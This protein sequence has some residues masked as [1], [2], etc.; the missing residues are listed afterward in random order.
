MDRKLLARAGRRRSV[1]LGGGSIISSGVLAWHLYRSTSPASTP[2]P[3]PV[4]SPVHNPVN[5]SSITSNQSITVAGAAPPLFSVSTR[6]PTPVDTSI[7][8]L[9]LAEPEYIS[10]PTSVQESLEQQ[11][12]GGLE[13]PGLPGPSPAATRQELQ[14]FLPRHLRR[15]WRLLHQAERDS[16][17]GR[18]VSDCRKMNSFMPLLLS[19]DPRPTLVI[20]SSTCGQC[21]SWADWWD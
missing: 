2:A 12:G 13:E 18:A 19:R 7:L 3:S 21:G 14:T 4:H 1:V 15:P 5:R 10:L 16:W 6:S 9:D 8:T 11:G 20:T 17:Q